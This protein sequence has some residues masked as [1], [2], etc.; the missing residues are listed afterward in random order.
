M[1]ST[2]E[3][4]VSSTSSEF[5]TRPCSLLMLHSMIT[6]AVK[7]LHLLTVERSL[8]KRHSMRLTR[9]TRS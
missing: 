8:C 5:G 6:T 7:P 9:T 1:A 2:N 3:R 4:G